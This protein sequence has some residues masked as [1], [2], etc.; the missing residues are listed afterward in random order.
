MIFSDRNPIPHDKLDAGETGD[1]K[2]SDMLE[3][4]RKQDVMQTKSKEVQKSLTDLEAT[5][6][7]CHLA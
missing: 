7:P 2:Q 6:E 1:G 4:A 3:L 5:V